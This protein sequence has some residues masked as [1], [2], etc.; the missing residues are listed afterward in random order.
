[1]VGKRRQKNCQKKKKLVP[2]KARQHQYLLGTGKECVVLEGIEDQLKEEPKE[3]K[4][5][6]KITRQNDDKHHETETKLIIPCE[7][8][9]KDC[10]PDRDTVP[11]IESPNA[12]CETTLA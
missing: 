7:H 9:G 2:R 5:L 6:S 4:E 12:Q 8:Q 3:E 10:V 11:F 1:M